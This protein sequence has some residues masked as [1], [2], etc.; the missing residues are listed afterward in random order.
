MRIL[1]F[2]KREHQ[3]WN[4]QAW[5]S[6]PPCN[7]M[8]SYL[9]HYCTLLAIRTVTPAAIRTITPAAIILSFSPNSIVITRITT[10]SHRTICILLL[11]QWTLSS[12]HPGRNPIS[13]C[14]L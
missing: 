1:G 2:P 10:T 8:A 14:C 3:L 5:L 11:T 13:I 4:H 12:L 7:E 6:S 9:G